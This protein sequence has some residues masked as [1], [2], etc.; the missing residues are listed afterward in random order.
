M[1]FQANRE[2]V[3]LYV[4]EQ[5]GTEPEYLW[6]KHPQYAVLRRRDNN[7][8]YAIVLNVPKNKLGLSGDEIVDILDVK[9]DPLL[10]GSLRT[11]PGF[12]PAYHM[13][14]ENWI[15]ILL[16]GS[17]SMKQIIGLLDM[18]FDMVKNHKKS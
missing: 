15:T 4:K 5:Y 14:K 16:D 12:L 9:C 13:N 2:S 11:N 18:S 1:G 7:K 10:I 6:R 3:F 17:V 8:W